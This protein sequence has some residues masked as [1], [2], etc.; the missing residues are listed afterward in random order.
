MASDGH[1]P[2]QA[3]RS[4]AALGDAWYATIG[5]EPAALWGVRVLRRSTLG[6]LA[7][8]WLLTTDVVERYRK[9]FWRESRRE[10]LR[11]LELDGG[12]IR[13]I[14]AIDARYEQA[15]RW[16]NRLGIRLCPP[17][18]YGTPGNA[19]CWFIVSKEDL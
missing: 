5:G 18:P 12:R 17:A 7:T 15:L 10:L 3:C 14:N 1:T 2:L 19:A 16:A 6:D 8:V 11:L 9:V 13:L 4:A